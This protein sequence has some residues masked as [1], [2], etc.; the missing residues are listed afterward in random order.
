MMTRD[1][2]VTRCD[3]LS[4][5]TK[6]SSKPW[7]IWLAEM[8]AHDAEQRAEIA[9][10]KH[11]YSQLKEAYDAKASGVPLGPIIGAQTIIN[12]QQEIA[13]LREQ[14]EQLRGD[15]GQEHQKAQQALNESSSTKENR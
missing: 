3:D 4:A 9:L 12:Q 8:T 11:E 6:Y 2:F 7:H 13:R 5:E 15:N 1:E 10:V 14:I